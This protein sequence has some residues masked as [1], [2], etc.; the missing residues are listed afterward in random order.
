M[1]KYIPWN[2]H[3]EDTAISHVFTLTTIIPW[4]GSCWSS[5]TSPNVDKAGALSPYRHSI[6]ARRWSAAQGC[7]QSSL[8]A[9]GWSQARG[10]RLCPRNFTHTHTHTFPA[11]VHSTWSQLCEHPRTPCLV[12]PRTAGQ[13]KAKLSITNPDTHSCSEE[14]Q[15]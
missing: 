10:C 9:M 6:K 7:S 8:W 5:S 1:D 12:S 2:K 15:A 13:S 11:C 3:A 14:F 4:T